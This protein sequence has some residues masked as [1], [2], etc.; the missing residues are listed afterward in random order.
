[1]DDPDVAW[2]AWKFGMKRDDL[3]TNL[4]EQYNTFT[5]NLQDPEAFHHDVYEISHDADTVDEFHR[6]MAERKQQRLCELH[7]SLESLAVEIIANPKLMDSEHWQHA[8]QLFRTK[9]F[10]SI[11][12]Y[13]ASYLPDNYIDRHDR[14]HDT[15]SIASSSFSEANSVK[16]ESTT[17]SSVDGPSSFFDDEPVMKKNPLSIHTDMR[18]SSI[19][20]APPSPPHSEVAHS[21]ESSAS[22]PVSME[23]HRYPSNPPSRSMS[24][25]GS[26]SGPFLPDLT[27]SLVHDDDET[28]QSDDN[29]D[30]VIS[31]SDCAESQ[32]SLDTM[33]EGEQ[34]HEYEDDLEEE[35]EFP[36]AQFPE[37]ASDAF[38]FCND[39]PESDDTPTPRQETIASCYIEY[40]SVAAWRIP[41]PRRSTSPS[42]KSHIHRR[43]SSVLKDI[44]RSPEES[45]T[46]DVTVACITARGSGGFGVDMGRRYITRY[47]PRLPWEQYSTEKHTTWIN[48]VDQ[49]LLWMHFMMIIAGSKRTLH[50]VPGASGCYNREEKK[51]L[52]QAGLLKSGR[53]FYTESREDGSTTIV[54]ILKDGRREI[55]P[56]NYNVKNIV[57]E[58]GG[59][60]YAVLPDDRI[61]FSNK[62]DTVHIVNPDSKEVSKLTGDPKLRYSNFEANLKSPW[63]LANQEDHEHDTPDSVRNYI[64]AINTETAEVKRILDTADFYYE[65]SF[66]PDGSKLAWLEWNH[67]ELPFD[68]ARL[69]TATWHQE[70]SIS[71]IRLIAGKDREGVAEPRWGPDGSLFFGKEAGEY[72]R[73]FR[74]LP[75]SDEQ[76]EVNVDGLDTAEFGGLRWFQGCHTYAPL[77]ERRLVAAPVILGQ[78]RV[79]LIDLESNSWEDIGDN[80]RL[81]EVTLD[82]VARLSD[83]SVLVIGAGDTT[84]KALYRIDVEG[85][86]HINELRSSADDRFPQSFCSKPILKSIRSKGQPERELNGFLWLPHNPDYQAPEG[87]LPPLI[88]ISHGGPT[89]YTGPGLN[90]RT[91]YFTSRGYAVLAFNYKGS[92]AHGQAY[93]NAL[94]G[95]W[96]L[97]DSDDA[98]EFANNLTET[99]QVRAGAVG[100]TGASA[101][102]YNTLRS[103]TRHAKTFAGGVCL[104]GV[105]D[106]KRLDDSTHKLE[107]DYTDHL[108]LA[109][110]VDKSEK[111]KICHERSPLFEAHKI[112]SPLLLLHGGADTITPLDQAQEM[113]NAIEK[114]GGQ[115]EL[116][117]VPEEGHGFSQPKNVRL[118]LEEEEKWWRRTLL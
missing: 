37:D 116:I 14:D 5:F 57:Y 20:Q 4:H 63:V 40:K 94:W 103:L 71:D 97:V 49:D 42:P 48:D 24:F 22:S 56:S 74:I 67:P 39:T 33:D 110:G 62:G 31:D 46:F 108:V 32:S 18:S 101:G 15:I 70:G 29:D 68:A 51:S 113:A 43:E 95:N 69:Y 83:T 88:M 114:A 64:V 76:R 1:M 12:R 28:S 16:T 21:D 99:G 23:S 19:V 10:D 90:P 87:H 45:L 47:I 35:D 17:A 80:E 3:F 79:I 92:C 105:S 11:V 78:S 117:V 96:G 65:P 36:T 41:S 13:F 8:L 27:R 118:W 82:A 91:Q 58:Y 34:P 102:G 66:S 93:R 53:A 9:S 75:G 106:I 61:I 25:S 109:P 54:E 81:S 111:D 60:T 107:S 89:S 26:E 112:T 2:P 59:S 104:S 6:L 86:S 73:L 30:A 77:S 84:G 38:D 55:I 52:S 50:V 44:R 115:V 100:I 72:R 85:T 7:E 98:A